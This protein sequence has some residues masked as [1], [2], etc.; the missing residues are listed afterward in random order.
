MAA[1]LC[2]LSACFLQKIEQV[3]NSTMPTRATLRKISGLA[4]FLYAYKP[5]Q[6][7]TFFYIFMILPTI[8]YYIY[9]CRQ[10]GAKPRNI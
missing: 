7:P 6:A 3:F 4:V 1:F 9:I 5:L 2:A 10:G 8:I